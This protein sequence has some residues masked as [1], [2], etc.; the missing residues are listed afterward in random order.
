MA[1]HSTKLWLVSYIPFD[2]SAFRQP[3]PVPP[4]KFLHIIKVGLQHEK[5]SLL[6]LNQSFSWDIPRIASEILVLRR[7]CLLNHGQCLSQSWVV[8]IVLVHQSFPLMFC[9][10]VK[11]SWFFAPLP[12]LISSQRLPNQ[13]QCKLQWWYYGKYL[14]IPIQS[15]INKMTQK[16]FQLVR[17]THA[18]LCS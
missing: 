9:S 8:S 13:I 15:L 7:L 2:P 6:P 11:Q 3:K 16:M 14:G 18:P 17:R 10:P 5:Q 1:S 12:P 4:G